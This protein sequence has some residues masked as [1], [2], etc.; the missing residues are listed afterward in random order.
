MK[1][2]QHHFWFIEDYEYFPEI[3]NKKKKKRKEEAN[4]L[5]DEVEITV[6]NNDVEDMFA[7]HTSLFGSI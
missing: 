1:K 2:A 4:E 6:N 7:S 5:I 3:A